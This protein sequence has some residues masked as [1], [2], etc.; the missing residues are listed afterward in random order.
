MH[1]APTKVLMLR[2]KSGFAGF[3][4][5]WH[6]ILLAPALSP[7]SAIQGLSKHHVLSS[8]VYWFARTSKW[9]SSKQQF[10]LVDKWLRTYNAFRAAWEPGKRFY[11]WVTCNYSSLGYIR[12]L[13]Q[14]WLRYSPPLILVRYS[15]TNACNV[16]V[17]STWYL[18]NLIFW[19]L[20]LFIVIEGYYLDQSHSNPSFWPWRTSWRTTLTSANQ[21]HPNQRSKRHHSKQL[22]QR[23]M[24]HRLFWLSGH[25]A[26]ELRV[27]IRKS[28]ITSGH[29]LLAGLPD[30]I[31]RWNTSVY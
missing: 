19:R 2:K 6:T 27:A 13:A 16:R 30:R 12:S 11:K 18:A 8:V 29:M 14:R 25:Q 9:P 7:L 1:A 31:Q 24:W 3:I 10:A 5:H 26:F 17:T 21:I 22:K 28:F 23:L 15:S 4:P 20:K